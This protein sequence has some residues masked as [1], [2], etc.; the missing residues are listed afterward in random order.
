MHSFTVI[1]PVYNAYHTLLDCLQSLLLSEGNFDV[2]II[3]DASTD[4]RVLPLLEVFIS[5]NNLNWKLESNRKNLGF[6]ETVNIGMQLSTKDV[7]LLNQDVILATQTLHLLHQKAISE[8]D[9]ASLTPLSNNAEIASVPK[10]CTNNTMPLNIET[11]AMV[12]A[13][14]T[15]PI[16]PEIPTGVGFCMYITRTALNKIGYFDAQ[17]FG[18]GYGEENDFC[19][20]ATAAGLKNIIC[21]TAY[22]AHIG[23]QSFSELGMKPNEKALSIIQERYPWY[24][25]A[26]KLFIKN[27]PLALRREQI[28]INY[29]EQPK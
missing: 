27:D 16:F 10:I 19:C 5:K 4:K 20:R 9:L 3:N 11:R 23:N 26:V 15:S 12:C 21:D 22:A 14:T 2:H 28:A 24:I 8:N 25:D 29:Q 1:L 7:V 18:H 13:Q 17:T 6:V